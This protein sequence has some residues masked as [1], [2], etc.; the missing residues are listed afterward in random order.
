M[1]INLISEELFNELTSIQKNHPVLT[2]KAKGYDTPK[3]TEQ[4]DIDAHKRVGEILKDHI[5]GFSS[6]TN[7]TPDN[8]IRLQHNYSY[9]EKALPF[10]GVGYLKLDELLNGFEV[11]NY[12]VQL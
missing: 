6:F 12:N 4:R 10:I 8:R 11:T 7:F 9:D 3:I 5:V 1:K 2:Y